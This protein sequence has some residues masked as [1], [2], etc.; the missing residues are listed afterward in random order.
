[1]ALNTVNFVDRTAVIIAIDKLSDVVVDFVGKGR[2]ILHSLLFLL[3][4]SSFIPSSSSFVPYLPL[5]LFPFM[6]VST[7]DVN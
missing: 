3:S 1:M 2:Q 6:S 5:Y 7:V 4:F